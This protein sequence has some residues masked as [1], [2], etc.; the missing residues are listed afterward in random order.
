M[1]KC[2]GGKS[3]GKKPSLGTKMA[4]QKKKGGCKSGCK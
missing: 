2:G 1:N 4:G 3:G